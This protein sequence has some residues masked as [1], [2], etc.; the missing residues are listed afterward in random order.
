VD[1]LLA[2]F[3]INLGKTSGTLYFDDVL[4]LEDKSEK[5]FNEILAKSGVNIHRPEGHDELFIQLPASAEEDLPLLIVGPHG[6]IVKTIYISKGSQETSID[7]SEY[8]TPG[9][10]LIQV[11]TPFKTL[12]WNFNVR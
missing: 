2:F 7:F 4:V 11:I 1:E 5:L 8:T 9:H 6:R 12:A 10:Y 3:I